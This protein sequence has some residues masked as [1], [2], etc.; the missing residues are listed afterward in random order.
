[1]SWLCRSAATPPTTIVTFLSRFDWIDPTVFS[2]YLLLIIVASLF[3]GLA[4]AFTI[5]PKRLDQDKSRSFLCYITVMM[6]SGHRVTP[7]ADNGADQSIP[8]RRPC[9]SC[10]TN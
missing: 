9:D 4:S 7:A 6:R 5:R 10:L 3:H 8:R 1:M 2:W